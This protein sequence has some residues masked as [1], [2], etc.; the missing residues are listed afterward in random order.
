MM[1]LFI[2]TI[3]VL[4]SLELLYFRMA[5]RYNIIDRPNERSSHKTVTLRGGGIVFYF[6]A[7]A[8][9]VVSGFSYPWFMLG[10]TLITVVSFIDDIHSLPDKY[11]LAI[12]FVSMFLMVIELGCFSF[13]WWF[14]LLSVVVCVGIVNA[15]NFMDGINGIT[16]GYSL[17]VLCGLLYVNEKVCSFVDTRLLLM[18]I[19]AGLVFCFFNFRKKARCFAGDVGAVSMAFV[20]VFLLARLMQETNDVG[21]IS[22]LWVYGVDSVLTIIHRIML[23]ENLG[24]AHRKHMFQIMANELEIPHLAVSLIYML[25]QALI[26]AFYIL[27]P[28]IWTALICACVLALVYVVFMKRYFK[29]HLENEN[30]S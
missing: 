18:M 8:F 9:F 30:Q 29:L 23:R 25:V 12:Q 7:L 16:G 14:L 17:V 1:Y 21:W 24:K 2:I 13:P 15:Y 22:F 4:F 3:V 5:D 10:L 26:I 28:S 19:S 11:R 6:G 20:V 27:I